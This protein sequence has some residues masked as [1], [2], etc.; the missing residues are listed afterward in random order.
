M[1]VIMLVGGYQALRAAAA[2]SLAAHG[3]DVHECSTVAEARRELGSAPPAMVVVDTVLP[4]GDGITFVREI[5]RTPSVLVIVCDRG[6]HKGNRAL[7][8][9]QAGA[10]DY[11]TGSCSTEEL[12]L[13][14]RAILERYQARS[15]EGAADTEQ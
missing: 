1:S 11:V 15:S 12:A 7:R 13:R 9:F 14:V 8:A 5:K 6:G 10:D 3:Y 2:E 4:D